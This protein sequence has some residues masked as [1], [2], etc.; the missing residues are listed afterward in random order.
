ML[1]LWQDFE[2]M[3]CNI[4]TSSKE[5]EKGQRGGNM[6]VK[7]V[8]TKGGE[9]VR[10]VWPKWSHATWCLWVHIRASRAYHCFY[11]AWRGG[12]GKWVWFG[13]YRV[14]AARFLQSVRPSLKMRGAMTCNVKRKREKDRGGWGRGDVELSTLPD[15]VY[16][17][18]ACVCVSQ[19]LLQ[20]QD[21]LPNQVLPRPSILARC[22]GVPRVTLR[23]QR[24]K[25]AHETH[26]GV[27]GG[28]LDKLEKI[29]RN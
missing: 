11:T 6:N 29:F 1:G 15:A 23:G 4:Q 18:L 8:G 20:T 19:A 3:K 7:S 16:W 28:R 12:A 5:Q 14:R 22:S 26:W 27:G 10:V 17:T 24:S 9:R 13:R 25:V 21:R 2:P